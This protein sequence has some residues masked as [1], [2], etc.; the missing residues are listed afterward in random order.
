MK[1][2]Y[3]FLLL[4]VLASQSCTRKSLLN[5]DADISDNVTTLGRKVVTTARILKANVKSDTLKSAREK[6]E[7]ISSEVAG[8]VSRYN[9]VIDNPSILKDQMGDLN[10]KIN[11]IQTKSL[12]FGKFYQDVYL[13]NPQK[14]RD[15]A[16]TVPWA[17]AA[18]AIYQL[19]K[20]LY[21]DIDKKNT[22]QRER[23]KKNNESLILPDWDKL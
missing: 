22:E 5:T 19:G 23:M 7:D 17:A 15:D 16:T 10:T 2:F 21:D 6:Y 4:I 8:L 9:R 18:T 12:D 3:L 11:T 20:G 1:P 13:N 14:S